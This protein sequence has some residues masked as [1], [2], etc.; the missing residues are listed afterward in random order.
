MS[1]EETWDA[2]G[3]QVHPKGV[4]LFLRSGVIK[5]NSN[6]STL[7]LANHVFTELAFVRLG[8]VWKSLLQSRENVTLQHTPHWGKTLRKAYMLV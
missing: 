8:Q 4:C 5:G 2:V 1:C 3:V 6:S 7:I